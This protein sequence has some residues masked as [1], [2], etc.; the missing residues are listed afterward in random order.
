MVYDFYY[1][2]KMEVSRF[3]IGSFKKESSGVV[4]NLKEA[5]L[6]LLLAVDSGNVNHYYSVSF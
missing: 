2:N 4:K 1:T 6:R 3:H 5:N